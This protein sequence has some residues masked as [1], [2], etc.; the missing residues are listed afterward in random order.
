MGVETTLFD[1]TGRV[2]LLTGASKG[3]GLSMAEGLA[4]H[5]ATVVVSSRKIEQCEA[6]AEQINAKCGE[7]SAIA[8]ACN[9]GYKEQLEAL[10]AETRSRLG[11][12]DILVANAGVNPFYGPMSEI[13]DSAFDKIM[14]TNVRSNHW[15]CRMVAPDM[16]EMGGGSMMITSS[17]GAFSAS[18]NLGTY[19]ISKLADIALVR[20]LALEYGPSGV[21]V[22]AICPGVVKTDF[23]R[24]LWDNP[25]AQRNAE[26]NTPLRRLGETE[27]LKGIAVFLA[28][29]ASAY[30]TGQAIAVCG[31]THMWP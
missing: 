3:M 17:T 8:I 24:A 31:G 22:N 1:L 25:E 26:T 19:A 6:A 7:G 28:A 5:G 12:I 16:V 10:V 11:P 18:A 15:L 27:D 30:I 20:N 2:A 14:S 9:V 29:D 21:R 4:E 13:P 23:A